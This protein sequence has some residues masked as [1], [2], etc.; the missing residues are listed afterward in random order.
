MTS[1]FG[2]RLLQVGLRG[3]SRH[4]FEAVVGGHG[5]ANQINAFDRQVCFRKSGAL[6][7]VSTGRAGSPSEK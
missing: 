4:E 2:S 5:I 1:V 7:I 3:K 6:I